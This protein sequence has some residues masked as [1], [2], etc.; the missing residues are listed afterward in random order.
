MK[1]TNHDVIRW[2]DDVITRVYRDLLQDAVD[3]HTERLL[4]MNP[5]DV[6]ELQKDFY[7]SRGA[8]D[9]LQMALDAHLMPKQEEENYEDEEIQNT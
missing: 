1:Y 4:N 3:L 5:K 9:G 7:L 6:D 8:I 2:K